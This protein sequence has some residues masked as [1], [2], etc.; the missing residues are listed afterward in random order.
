M[1]GEFVN[2]LPWSS[3]PT[4]FANQKQGSRY[5]QQQWYFTT[6]LPLFP[7]IG[8]F[9]IVSLRLYQLRWRRSFLEK[10]TLF[11]LANA[12][13]P[14]ISSLWHTVTP[15]THALAQNSYY[16]PNLITVYCLTWKS[17]DIRSMVLASG[18]RLVTSPMP[19]GR[20]WIELPA[21]PPFL[22]SSP[23]DPCKRLWNRTKSGILL[24]PSTVAVRG[25]DLLWHTLSYVHPPVPLA[26]VPL[27]PPLR[28][29]M[30]IYPRENTGSVIH[31]TPLHSPVWNNSL[32]VS[33]VFSRTLEIFFSAKIPAWW[34]SRLFCFCYCCGLRGEKQAT[35]PFFTNT[36]LT[37]QADNGNDKK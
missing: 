9:F 15:P 29:I 28:R 36:N 27:P 25:N 3:I 11:L 23:H 8:A 5:S 14:R 21:P 18:D 16:L 33:D 19:N 4:D 34:R 1:H 2:S 10:K 17:A 31:R 24:S 6:V 12:L 20:L 13:F 35:L 26:R 30:D 37:S 32:D 7:L 22:L